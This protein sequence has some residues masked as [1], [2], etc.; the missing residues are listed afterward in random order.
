MKEYLIGADWYPEDWEEF[1]TDSDIE[2]MQ[3]MG[4]NTVRIGEFAW[5][6]DEP[7]EGSFDFAWLERVVNKCEAAGLKVIMGTPTATPPSWFLKKYPDAAC[8]DDKGIRASHGGRR[9]CCSTN[10][11]YREKSAVIVEKLAQLFGKRKCIV[12]WQ[13][14]NEIYHHPDKGYC[15]CEHC[16]NAFREHLREKYHSVENLNKSWN[17]TLFSQEYQSFED[18][19]APANAWHNPHLKL[20]WLLSQ[21]KNHENFVKMQAE[22]IKRFSRAPVGTDTMPLNGFD[23]RRLES[24]LDVVQFNCYYRPEHWHSA[25][26]WLDYMRGFSKEHFWITETQPSWPGSTGQHFDL[27]P[28]GYIY[29]NSMLGPVLGGGGLLYWLWRT[30]WAGHE[31][32]HGAVLETCGRPAHT[33]GEIKRAAKDA[34][35]LFEA[36]KDCSCVSEAALIFT[37]L[38]WNMALSQDISEKLKKPGMRDGIPNEFYKAMLKTGIHPHVVDLLEDIS[39]YKL[40]VAP[41]AFTLE[42]GSFK[43]RACEWVKNGG[44]LVAGPLTDIRTAIGTKYKDRALGFLEELTGARLEYTVPDSPKGLVLEDKNGKEVSCRSSFELYS[45][46]EPLIKVKEGHSA[47]RGLSVA[48][49]CKV[50]KGSVILL[51]SFPETDALIDILKLAADLA[52]L[53]RYSVSGDLLVTQMKGEKS[54]TKG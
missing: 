41:G 22:I 3:N 25:A 12:G 51:G 10:P 33:A 5:S 15:F 52:N 16:L 19:P 36:T 28:E 23:Y 14:D 2:K 45:N 49:A 8:L 48:G 43:E 40:I 13:I 46:V 32:M 9:H 17:L 1:E 20:E 38:N 37:S 6:K 35:K 24:S 44:V 31:L 53:E 18:I 54:Y 39:S 47:L 21:A 29:F 11:H 26:M 27:P 42:E 34:K 7:S 4:F 30:H 50:G